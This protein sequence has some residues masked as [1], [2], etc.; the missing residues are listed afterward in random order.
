MGTLF[1]S[2][3]LSKNNNYKFHLNQEENMRLILLLILVVAIG[4]N[5]Q[6]VTNNGNDEPVFV[7][8]LAPKGSQ[9]L[10]KKLEGNNIFALK[11]YNILAHNKEENIFFSPNSISTALAM[12]YAG[13]KGNTAKEMKETL[14]FTLDDKELHNAFSAL[15]DHLNGKEKKRGYELRIANRLWGQKN[16]TFLPEFV[17]ITRDN[18]GAPIEQLDF[19]NNTEGARQRINTWVEERTEQ[20]IKNLI[21][22][23]ILSANTRLVL[24]NAIYFKGDWKTQFK[25]ANTKKKPFYVTDTKE[26]QVDMMF[27]KRNATI[28]KEEGSLRFFSYNTKEKKFLYFS[29]SLIKNMA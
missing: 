8:K 10:I 27:Q 23:G 20:K 18:Y 1:N 12:T 9:K 25:K 15:L 19:V 26:V 17:K 6:A 29:F 21:A 24:T 3:E 16:Y 22:K 2:K 5:Q 11:L 13:A 7:K 14:H 28:M 4:C